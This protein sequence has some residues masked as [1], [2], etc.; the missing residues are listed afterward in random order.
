MKCPLCDYEGEDVEKHIE[1]EHK[2]AS[3]LLK[4]LKAER[5][6]TLEEVKGM[7]ID[8]QSKTLA[9]VEERL[10]EVRPPSV[11]LELKEGGEYELTEEQIGMFQRL[12]GRNVT[13]D[14]IGGLLHGIG[15][16]IAALRGPSG[17]SPFEEAGREMFRVFVREVTK[18][19]AKRAVKHRAEHREEE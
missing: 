4:L 12:F 14:Q 7:L 8:F 6:K 3:M 5:E 18:G 1:E 9:A 11:K 15:A 2:E 19:F 17:P 10:E 13:P 16:M